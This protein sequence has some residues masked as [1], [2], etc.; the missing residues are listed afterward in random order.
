MRKDMYQVLHDT[1]R[2]G[3]AKNS[4][5]LRLSAKRALSKY[6]ANDEDFELPE[7][8]SAR[9]SLIRPH[10][11]KWL[12]R[13]QELRLAPLKRYIASRVG[14]PWDETYSELRKTLVKCDSLLVDPLRYLGVETRT[15]MEAGEVVVLGSFGGTY[16]LDR[17]WFRYYVHPVTGLLCEGTYAQRKAAAQRKQEAERK[18]KTANRKV[19]SETQELRCIEGIWYEVSFRE[20]P[21]NDDVTLFQQQLHSPKYMGVNGFLRALKDLRPYD[22]VLAREVTARDAGVLK[23]L[24]GKSSPL[25]ACKKRQLSHKELIQYGI[26]ASQAA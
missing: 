3:P 21:T 25:Y 10:K 18:Q 22:V 24:H 8:E 9:K 17:A 1:T 23:R 5:L 2:R 20:L 12:N 13:S 26:L 19:L 4:K 11:E 15:R 6:S 14:Q 7:L 16:S